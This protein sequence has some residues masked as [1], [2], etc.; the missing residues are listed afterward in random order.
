[1]RS[2]NRNIENTDVDIFVV[3][4]TLEIRNS[5]PHFELSLL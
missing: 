3:I 5:I 4:I 1:M 2:W